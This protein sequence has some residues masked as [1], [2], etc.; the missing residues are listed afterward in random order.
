M[1]CKICLLFFVAYL[2]KHNNDEK[3]SYLL[4]Q[5][6]DLYHYY[7]DLLL[8]DLY[9]DPT[10]FFFCIEPYE[11]YIDIGYIFYIL[12]HNPCMLPTCLD[13]IFLTYLYFLPLIQ[14]KMFLHCLSCYQHCYNQKEDIQHD[15]NQYNVV[16]N[17]N[18]EYKVLVPYKATQKN[19]SFSHIV[20]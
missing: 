1:F 3:Q 14:I 6:V 10:K 8:L 18:I 13:P 5:E 20:I 15:S 9:V 4:L 7:A 12:Q 17:N 19:I 16:Y 11:A 2:L